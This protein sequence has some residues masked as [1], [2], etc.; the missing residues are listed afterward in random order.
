MRRQLIL[1]MMS[2][3][4]SP[5]VW[6]VSCLTSWPAWPA[7]PG[8]SWPTSRVVWPPAGGPGGGGSPP[9]GTR[10][11]P[12]RTSSGTAG[13][14]P[15]CRTSYQTGPGSRRTRA[16]RTPGGTFRPWWS[17]GTGNFRPGS[18][19]SPLGLL[20]RSSVCYD[21]L[22]LRTFS[23]AEVERPE[24]I[25]IT[26]FR[27]RTLGQTTSINSYQLLVE[28]QSGSV[29]NHLQENIISSVEGLVLLPRQTSLAKESTARRSSNWS[30]SL[31]T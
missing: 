24:T 20:R 14:P 4:D 1:T 26:D 3:Q 22:H 7:W 30:I 25:V 13:R 31:L 28:P 23:V 2:R 21:E 17:N 8:L 5:R 12:P 18:F 27:W 11:G 6:T 9:A 10:T 15:Q 19:S 29:H 16:C